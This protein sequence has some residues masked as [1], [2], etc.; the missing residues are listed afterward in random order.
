[1]RTVFINYKSPLARYH[2]P[3][4]RALSREFGANMERVAV[5]KNHLKYKSFKEI[6]TIHK[7]PGEM[8]NQRDKASRNTR[9]GT[10]AIFQNDYQVQNRE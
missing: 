5:L 6:M 2:S 7:L 4:E 3:S 9:T 8:R 10:T 1:M